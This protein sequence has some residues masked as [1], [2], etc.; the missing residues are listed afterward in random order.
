[1]C[2]RR[3]IEKRF[4]IGFRVDNSN[5]PTYFGVAI[6]FVVLG[7]MTLGA[8]FILFGFPAG[9]GAVTI[10]L[11]M[12]VR[13]RQNKQPVAGCALTFDRNSVGASGAT[14]IDTDSNG[15]A[16]A[17]VGSSQSGSLLSSWYR[18]ITLET[19]F[20][21][22]VPRHERWAV[23]VPFRSPWFGSTATSEVELGVMSVTESFEWP[24]RAGEITRAEA[25]I[26]IGQENGGTVYGVPLELFLN[27]AQILACTR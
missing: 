19:V 12:T 25:T 2:V 13:D 3:P 18:N 11:T 1:M 22:G 17:R 24:P 5:A 16:R 7:S 10:D 23:K 9:P 20:Y 6:A 21:L 14:E 4:D 8:S 26:T 15:I 27:R